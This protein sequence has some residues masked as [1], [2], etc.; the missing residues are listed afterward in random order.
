MIS[1]KLVFL[2]SLIGI[3]PVLFW[4]FFMLKKGTISWRDRRWLISVFWLGVLVAL[5]V[6]A[7][8]V[9]F[10]EKLNFTGG[11]SRILVMASV[12]EV[13]KGLVTLVAL[14]RGRFLRSKGL[15]IGITVGLA[16]AVTENGVYFASE[17]SEKGVSNLVLQTIFLRFILS[18]SAHLIYSGT[19][20]FLLSLAFRT[21]RIFYKVSVFALALILPLLFHCGFNFALTTGYAFLAPLL[22][23]VG[24]LLLWLISRLNYPKIYEK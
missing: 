2:A 3:F 9:F 8:E 12:E 5:P 13:L 22:I 20:G 24:L 18:T 23:A 7:L 21:G 10:I 6:G 11:F 15:V 4:T 19:M 1:Y 17:I 14:L 16:F